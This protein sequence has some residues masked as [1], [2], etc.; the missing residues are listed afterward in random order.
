MSGN[1]CVCHNA[2]DLKTFKTG[3]ILVAHD[4]NNMMMEQIRQAS[5]IIVEAEN[6]NCHAAIVGLSLDIP[7]IIG[8]ENALEILKSSAYVELDAE[9]GVVSA[10]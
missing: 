10:N 8:A 1:L 3:D 7:V 5:G 9:N 4:T 2:D 6:E